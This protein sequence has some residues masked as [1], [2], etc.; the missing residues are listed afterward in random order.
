MKK[1][2]LLIV[3]LFILASCGNSD[4]SVE[5]VIEEGNLSEIRAKK[6]ELS[7]QQGELSSKIA[8]LDAAIQKL[9]KRTQFAL[10]RTTRVED[11]LFKHYVEI[12]GDVETDENITIYPEF[13]GVLLDVLVEEG[14]RVNK[15]QVLARIDD[16]GLSSQL[17][18]LETQAA[19]AKTTFERQKRLWEQN[20]GSEIQFLE[21]KANYEAVQNSVNQLQSQLSKTVVRAPFSGVI[22]ETFSEQGEVV[23]PGQSRLFRLINLSNMYITAAVPESYLGS[24]KKGTEV[25][26][27]IAATGTEFQSEIQQVGNFINPNNRTFEIKVAVPNDKELVKPNLIATVKLND[28]TSENAVIIPEGVIQK[29]AAGQSVIYVLQPT[30]DSTGTAEKRILETGKI[31]NDHVEVLSGLKPGELLIT[32]G[33][34]NISEGEEVKILN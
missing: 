29:N 25:M 16:G 11:T 20:I 21:A 7:K 31:Y 10:V 17:A 5:E 27:E 18:Q 6:A 34:K 28:Y 8:K 22:D 24:I 1:I 33:A 32:E 4:R 26:V 12:P 23:A 9:D 14:D 30:N 15:G 3:S 19:L 2:S 13:S